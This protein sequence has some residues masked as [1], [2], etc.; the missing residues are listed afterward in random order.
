MKRLEK[1]KVTRQLSVEEQKNVF[2]GIDCYRLNYAT[3]QSGS[4]SPPG[5]DSA[6]YWMLFW[7]SAGYDTRCF[8]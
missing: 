7:E 8:G 1:L 4:Y 6:G 2:G 5:V 3:G